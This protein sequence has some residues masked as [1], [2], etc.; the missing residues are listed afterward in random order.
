MGKKKHD[1]QEPIANRHILGTYFNMAFENFN[2]T[3]YILCE[4]KLKISTSEYGTPDTEHLIADQPIQLRKALFRYLPFLAPI[5]DDWVGYQLRSKKS[6]GNG[7]DENITQ[8]Q[9][10]AKLDS[11]I[12]DIVSQLNIFAQEL[13]YCRNKYTHKNAYTL[14]WED[15]EH[16]QR[17][18]QIA[19]M[20]EVLMKAE[21]ELLKN[22]KDRE[23]KSSAMEL[24]LKDG[25]QYYYR[26]NKGK[27]VRNKQFYFNP[28]SFELT[29]K[30]QVDYDTIALTD[31]GRFY[32]CSLFLRSRD[33]ERFATEMKIFI[34]S[35]WPDIKDKDSNPTTYTPSPEN[36]IMREVMQMHRIH[37]PREKRID[38]VPSQGTLLMDIL[39][40]LRRCPKILFDTFC[41]TTKSSFNHIVIQDDGTKTSTLMV[42]HQDRFAQLALRYIDQNGL[43]PNI[44][45][46]LRL[47]LFRFRFYDKTLIDGTPCIRTVHKELNGYGRLQVVEEKRV[48]KWGDRFQKVTTKENEGYE[49]E[50]LQPDTP[51]TDPYVTDWRSTYNIHTGRIGMSWGEV[52]V[53]G[54]TEIGSAM[55]PKV[56][57]KSNGDDCYYIPDLPTLKSDDGKNKDRKVNIPQDAPLCTM[58]TYDLPALL[59]Y[60]YL[61]DSYGRKGADER[62]LPTSENIILEKC[63]AL[64]ALFKAAEDN[65]CTPKSL[66]EKERELG[67]SDNEIPKKL[68]SYLDGEKHNPQQNRK[69]HVEHVLNGIINDI[70]G[71]LESFENKEK[72]IKAGGRNNRY[73]NPHHADVRHGS[74]ARYLMRSMLRW[75]SVDVESPHFGKLT[76]P[77]ARTLMGALA[78]F[79]SGDERLPL[80]EI[81]T[82]ANMIGG[83]N[84]H[85]FIEEAIKGADNIEK[86]YVAYLKKE[87]K[88]AEKI[89]RN[90]DEHLQSLPPF[91]RASDE[92]NHWGVDL[93]QQAYINKYA[94]KLSELPIQLPDGL[95]TKYIVELLHNAT[96]MYSELKIMDSIVD[97]DK[98]T[99][100]KGGHKIGDNP[101]SSASHIIACYFEKVLGDKSQ[102]FYDSQTKDYKRFYENI[103]KLNP[104]RER[105]K[106]LIPDY[107]TAKEIQEKIKEARKSVKGKNDDDATTLRD[108]LNQVEEKE[109]AIRLFRV[110]DM[111]LFL[112]A[113]QMLMSVVGRSL[114]EDVNQTNALHESKDNLS[115]LR[116]KAKELKLGQFG[117]DEDFRFLSEGDNEE[118][119]KEKDQTES[120]LEYIYPYKIRKEG[121]LVG[122]I[123][124]KQKGLSLK[125]YG[126]IYSILGDDRLKSLMEG[127]FEIGVSEVTFGDITSEF[128]NFDQLRSTILKLLQD[129][130]EEI[131]F[132][133]NIS[134]LNNPRNRNFYSVKDKDGNQLK[135]KITD[136]VTNEIIALSK[137]AIRNQF[138]ELIKMLEEYEADRVSIN[139]LRKA[140][141]HNHYPKDISKLKPTKNKKLQLPN[142]A[143]LANENAKKIIDAAQKA[144]AEKEKKSE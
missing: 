93:E 53:G 13:R 31:F 131:A 11:S 133:R 82:A 21:R 113:K 46:Q 111:V 100:D 81:L 103:S 86:L 99:T 25:D 57:R 65:T 102:K 112:S 94:A 59:F 7:G 33:A 72:R 17:E 121:K 20:L 5:M 116:I 143:H 22:R 44:R 85:P 89:L 128:A 96:K 138:P 87:K 61:I 125:N 104:R 38:A 130:I 136:P 58:S 78:A 83:N 129:N 123:N 48:A 23:K 56:D 51:Q 132:N 73:G 92:Q 144:S 119:R 52:N 9:K 95:F 110:E 54:K 134:V 4:K 71:R 97:S 18:K 47:G 122:T 3:M 118:E 70:N 24:F 107:F 126:N 75:Q 6:K 69:K 67:L 139:E 55:L 10:T 50:Q 101:S 88:H 105:N 68:L 79:G 39:E 32:F 64:K 12:E 62:K 8:K 66:R 98:R 34:E 80:N 127:L 1:K 19:K 37:V 49:I 43:F 36:K 140:V 84:P 2:R 14:A 90:I 28:A 137:D 106:A 15:E 60:Q 29:K 74:L 45:F 27:T 142:I 117:F 91:L 42:R 76:S 40:E 135:I 115:Q 109:R 108:K 77:N 114:T 16:L 63:Y 120:L 124:I 26:T 141:A 30:G 41:P 35:P